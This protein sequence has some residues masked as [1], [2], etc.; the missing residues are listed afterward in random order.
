MWSRLI[1]GR[2]RLQF[3]GAGIIMAAPAPALALAPASALA[4]ALGPAPLKYNSKFFTKIS[5]K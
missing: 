4:P 1:F 3:R 2:L 5:L